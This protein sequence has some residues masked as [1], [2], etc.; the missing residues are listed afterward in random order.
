MTTLS[1]RCLKCLTLLVLL[2]PIESPGRAAPDTS[3]MLTVTKLKADL[4]LATTM[5]LREGWT[6]ETVA[7]RLRDLRDA[8]ER[9]GDPAKMSRE[10]AAALTARITTGLNG[11]RLSRV[12]QHTGHLVGHAHIDAQWLWEWPETVLECKHTFAQAL[13]FMD[14]FKG[15]TFSQS[16]TMFYQAT[17]YYWPELFQNIRAAVAQGRWELVGG[18]VTETDSNIVSS[19]AHARQF[20]YWQRYFRERFGG[21]QASVA[22]APDTFG[23]NAQG[24]QITRLG[25]G[26]P[27][28]AAYELGAPLIE[29]SQAAFPVLQI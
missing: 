16:S 22:W 19:E 1:A 8:I 5:A 18:T 21:K 28:N 11:L 9:S 26:C 17:E 3:L 4:D 29:G 12:R 23:H 25:G 10:Q 15:F 6:G 13:K 2:A 7:G 20:L 27:P 24:P 14:E